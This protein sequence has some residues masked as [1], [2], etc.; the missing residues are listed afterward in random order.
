MSINRQNY[1]A[2]EGCVGVGKTTLAENLSKFRGANLV[3]EDFQRNPFLEDFYA[4]PTS[5]VLE[6]S[7]Q[8]LL[9]HCHQ[10]KSLK[11]QGKAETVTDFT[12]FKDDI[13]A[14]INLHNS[15]ERDIFGKTCALLHA[16][17]PTPDLVIYIRGSNR[18]IVDRIRRRNRPME[19][20]TD[21]TYFE[22]I[23]AAYEIFFS[24]FQAPLHVVE[25]D[26]YDCLTDSGYIASLS[27]EIDV[28]LARI[29]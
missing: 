21:S 29:G 19:S 25:A 11:R 13:F 24:N 5:N 22:K 2:I 12:V 4:D 1:I 27:K 17:L 9:L 20:A 6:N 14:G 23:N 15:A 28:A 3:L 10:I 7:L 16:K 8:F 18:L 26:S